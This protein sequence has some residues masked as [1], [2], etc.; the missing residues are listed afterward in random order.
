[1]RLP[2][3]HRRQC[4]TTHCFQVLEYRSGTLPVLTDYSRFGSVS[5]AADWQGLDAPFIVEL[6]TVCFFGRTP[7]LVPAPAGRCC[8]R[9]APDASAR[10]TNLSSLAPDWPSWLWSASRG[11][12]CSAAL[13]TRLES[14]G[15][16]GLHGRVFPARP[17]SRAAT[18]FHE[19]ESGDY[20]WL[21]TKDY[22]Q[23]P[24]SNVAG[25]SR[26]TTLYG[27]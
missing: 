27:T 21:V 4:A 24:L 3:H 10:S 14:N 6:F 8:H 9:Q 25:H 5:A 1:M 17:Y 18:R 19:I 16:A 2:S 15:P 11:G 23:K 20:S 13:R 26:G 7:E 12:I 22:F